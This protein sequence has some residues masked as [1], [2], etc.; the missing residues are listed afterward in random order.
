LMNIARSFSFYG[1]DDDD[2]IS[3]PISFTVV[4][5]ANNTNDHFFSQWNDTVLM[6]SGD[7]SPNVKNKD[8]EGNCLFHWNNNSGWDQR[9]IW[10]HAVTLSGNS[11]LSMGWGAPD[12]TSGNFYIWGLSDSTK[13]YLTAYP[14]VFMLQLSRRWCH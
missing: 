5:W 6:I 2:S 10:S 8:R 14:S 12:L 3:S 9:Q 11:L 1:I 4:I 7:I 13:S